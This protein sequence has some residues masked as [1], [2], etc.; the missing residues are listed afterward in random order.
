[1]GFIITIRDYF[2]KHHL[3][4]VLVI[5]EGSFFCE[6]FYVFFTRSLQTKKERLT[7]MSFPSV[8]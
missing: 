5:E 6:N 8:T 4:I 1:L 7:W 3:P 2:S